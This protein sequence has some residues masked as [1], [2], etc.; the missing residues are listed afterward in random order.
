MHLK[1]HHVHSSQLALGY[2]I[3]I[4]SWSKVTTY[5]LDPNAQHLVAISV[6][7]YTLNLI[8]IRSQAIIL[9]KF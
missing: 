2:G 3:P 8:D 5:V 4:S 9:L 7:F 6:D 1:C